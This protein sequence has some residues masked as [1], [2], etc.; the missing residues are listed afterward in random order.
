M[1]FCKK[2]VFAAVCTPHTSLAGVNSDISS[3]VTDRD[4][5]LIYTHQSK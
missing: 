5:S 4:M 1:C 3:D 2:L